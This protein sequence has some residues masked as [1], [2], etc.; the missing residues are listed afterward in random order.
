MGDGG[1]DGGVGEWVGGG[2]LR[3]GGLCLIKGYVGGRFTMTNRVFA[4][5]IA[6]TP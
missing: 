2:G 4:P 6:K 3:Y 5:L 1:W